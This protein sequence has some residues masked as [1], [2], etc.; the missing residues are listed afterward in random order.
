VDKG[1]EDQLFNLGAKFIF[2]DHNP[3]VDHFMEQENKKRKVETAD[4]KPRASPA[5][6]WIVTQ[7]DVDSINARK[8]ELVAEKK[9]DKEIEKI[10]KSE[11]RNKGL[12]IPTTSQIN[13]YIPRILKG[14]VKP[15]SMSAGVS[16]T[17]NERRK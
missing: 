15:K 7:R 4:K 14:D 2:G 1:K 8:K 12:D 3:I 13:T 10:I 5:K 9:S 17:V 6:P 16:K 11:W